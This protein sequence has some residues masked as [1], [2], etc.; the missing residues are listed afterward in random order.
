[1]DIPVLPGYSANKSLG[2]LYYFN[3]DQSKV[4]LYKAGTHNATV[5]FDTTKNATFTLT[6][7]GQQ[8]IQNINKGS[9]TTISI[10]QN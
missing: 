1:M 10:T 7:D 6:Q 3:D 9:T 5:T 2:L 8:I 4:T